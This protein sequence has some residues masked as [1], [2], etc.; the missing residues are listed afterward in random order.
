MRYWVWLPRKCSRKQAWP[1]V[2]PPVYLENK[3]PEEQSTQNVLS[4]GA[5]WPLSSQA[6]EEV[7]V[8]RSGGGGLFCFD[9]FK[10]L[11]QISFLKCCSRT[12]CYLETARRDRSRQSGC[13]LADTLA[14][15]QTPCLRPRC[16]VAICLL[17]LISNSCRG[18][19]LKDRFVGF[20]L[21]LFLFFLP[22]MWHSSLKS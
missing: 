11:N 4:P 17:C 18:M 12:Q 7:V 3:G 8:H 6:W 2:T 9:L 19:K 13:I 20:F 1:S 15:A 16:P 14:A 5:T 21:F 10:M 22:I